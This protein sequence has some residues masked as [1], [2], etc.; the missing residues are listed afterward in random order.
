MDNKEF[1]DWSRRAADWGADYRASLRDRPVRPAITPGEIFRSIEESPPETAEPM[2]NIFADFE[3]KIVPGMTH[4]QHPRF[5]A[6]FPANAAPVS[7]VAEYLV[8][9]MAAQCMLWQT[10]PAATELETRVVDWMR[11]A[12]GLPEGFS[13]VIQDSASSATLAAVL[14]MR[15]RALQW[16]GNRQ[17]LAGQA[18]LRV[19][20]S[21]Q[22]HTSID[23]A[24]WIAGIGGEN[25]VRIPVVGPFRAME[26]AA[27]EA[28]IIADR[29]AGL[30]P[31][32][33][34]AC[35]GGTST[36]GTDDIAAVSAVAKRHGLYLH[37]DAAW[38]GSAMICPEY[39]HFWA[40]VEGA[41]SI[42]FNPH[43]WLGAQF[44]CSMQFIRQPED[45]VRTLAIKPE[46]LKT[47]GHDG[48]INYSE[49]TVP[50]GRRFRALKLWFLLRARGLEGLRAMIRRHVAWSE[51][52]AE[53]LAGEADFE[54]VTEPML[55]LFSFRHRTSSGA[56]ADEHNLRLV[57]AINTDGRIYLTQTRVDGRVA[58]RFQ[59]GQFET[60]AADIEAAFDV[61]TEVARRLA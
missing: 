7:V 59:V 2:E 18:R 35:V 53:R 46:F 15:E 24:I 28:A 25:L 38:A 44:D 23:R 32:G 57:D 29:D 19:Y 45:L 3:A 56:D 51:G 36:G 17:G 60:T 26:T 5:F 41:D 22:V 31:A 6:Y 14:T 37:V 12:L 54:I 27:L 50:L 42:V 4:W 1:R 30:L 9:A 8:S 58:I 49:W 48:I 52:L 47:H 43:K 11:Q 61:V 21:D 13:G 16:Q 34:I 20:S 33:I 40:G 55:S 39:R 10:S